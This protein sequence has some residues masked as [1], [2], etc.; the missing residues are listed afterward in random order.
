MCVCALCS[1]MRQAFVQA[2]EVSA[3]LQPCEQQSRH[4]CIC[5]S[6]FFDQRINFRLRTAYT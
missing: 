3:L 4:V 5:C 6:C 2:L 1:D